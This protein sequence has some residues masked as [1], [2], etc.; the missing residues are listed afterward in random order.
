MLQ[1]MKMDVAALLIAGLIQPEG[2]G[3]RQHITAH[4]PDEFKHLRRNHLLAQ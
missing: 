3:A 1:S 4:F 2:P